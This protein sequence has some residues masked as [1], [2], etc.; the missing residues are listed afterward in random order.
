MARISLS[1]TC[2][3]ITTSHL[4]D[5]PAL[6]GNG[7]L[8]QAV[9]H[10][11][12][13][14][15]SGPDNPHWGTHGVSYHLNRDLWAKTFHSLLRDNLCMKLKKLKTSYW[16]AGLIRELYMEVEF[17]LSRDGRSENNFQFDAFK[18]SDLA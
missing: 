9:I 4:V 5:P 15:N 11:D 7:V 8:I 13:Q 18:G 2:F 3:R 1:R 10:A 16:F 17:C 14:V 12:L 6:D